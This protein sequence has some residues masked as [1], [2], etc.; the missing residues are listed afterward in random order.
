[1]ID[2][3][4]TFSKLY[5]GRIDAYGIYDPTLAREYQAVKAP[6]TTEL[7]SSTWREKSL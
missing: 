5:K 2:A 6:L 7:I 1:M 4:Q 3:A